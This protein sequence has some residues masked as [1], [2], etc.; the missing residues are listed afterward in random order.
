LEINIDICSATRPENSSED[1]LCGISVVGG[2]TVFTELVITS[3]VDSLGGDDSRGGYMK[4]E[5]RDGRFIRTVTGDCD[6]KQIGDEW[7]IFPNKSI[8]SVF[9][10]CELPMIKTRTLHVGQ[11]FVD[12]GETGTMV[13]EVLRK[14]R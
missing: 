14:I 8:A 6:A 10:G 1:K 13:M 12:K 11:Q 7:V 3:G 5:N 2:G 4:I 9:N